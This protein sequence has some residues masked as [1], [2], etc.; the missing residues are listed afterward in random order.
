MGKNF[1]FLHPL[2]MAIAIAF[3]V[4]ASITYRAMTS[5]YAKDFKERIITPMIGAIDPHLLYNPTFMV[6][7]HL[8]ERSELFK[9]SIDRYSGND[10]V[11]GSIDGVPLEFSDVHAEYQTRDSKGR[12]QWHTLFRR[13]FLVAEFNKHFKAKTVVLHDQAEKSF[14]SLIGGW[15]QSINFTREGL[16][17]MDDPEFEKHFVVYGSD[18][19]EARYILSHSMMKRILDFQR[20]VSHPLFISFV[21]NH[22]H[23][24]IG[25]GKDLFEPA[26]F[27]SLLDCK[28][29]MEYVNTLQ[30][31][32]GLVEEL[33]LNEK[34]WSKE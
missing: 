3:I 9:H 17:R 24:G 15:L 16:V 1:G 20:R 10:Y 12:T 19:I 8:F 2:M 34:L 23:V 32:I 30:N 18:Q 25:T 5:G 26:V 14:G 21:H 28:Q 6:S 27:T 22:I 31:T 33:K 7:Q 4:L 11:K 29:A 13:L